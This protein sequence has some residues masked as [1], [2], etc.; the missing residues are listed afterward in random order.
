[1]VP[2]WMAREDG[3]QTRRERRSR[4]SRAGARR[5][6][7][8]TG[9]VVAMHQLTVRA[10]LQPRG[11]FAKVMGF[12]RSAIEGPKGSAE[13]GFAT[14]LC[15]GLRSTEIKAQRHSAKELSWMC[16]DDNRHLGLAGGAI[17]G[18]R[19]AVIEAGGLEAL[20]PLLKGGDPKTT[21]E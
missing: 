10:L 13:S 21:G 7:A 6:T 11:M 8:S 9:S 14:V 15:E 5:S 4:R 18:N 17:H 2:R 20:V 16:G 12:V 3:F 1:M 19:L